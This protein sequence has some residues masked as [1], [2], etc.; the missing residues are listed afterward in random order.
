VPENW[1]PQPDRTADKIWLTQDES[2]GGRCDAGPSLHVQTGN[3]PLT[4]CQ[5]RSPLADQNFTDVAV[6][7]QVKV[8][9]GCAGLWTRTGSK[10]Y[11]LRVCRDRAELHLL[12]DAPPSDATRLAQ[13][14]FGAPASGT[15]VVALEAQGNTLTGYINGDDLVHAQ[16]G[17]VTR[18]KVNAGATADNGTA[19]DVTFDG[20]RVFA[21][22][23]QQ[24][25]PNPNQTKKHP[26]PTS[27]PT[28][29]TTPSE[30][31]PTTWQPTPTS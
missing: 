16:N 12:K 2:E 31:P 7:V 6:E 4:G 22:P 15:L 18:G 10:G 27:S 26:S 11:L 28:W 29:D 9:A 17:E 20:F 24:N 25:N 23:Q 30:P 21:P 5:L 3:N 19:A 8:T 13:A 1:Q 14:S